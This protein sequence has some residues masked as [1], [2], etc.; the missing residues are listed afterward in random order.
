MTRLAMSVPNGEMLTG[1]ALSPDGSK[2]AM[3]LQPEINKQP[4][5]TLVKVYT[6]ATGAVRTWTGNGTI[7]FGPG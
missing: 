4:D 2:L 5:L 1:L 6:L 3:A 7:G